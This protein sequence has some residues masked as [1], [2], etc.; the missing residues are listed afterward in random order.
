MKSFG[1]RK[2]LNFCLRLFKYAKVFTRN[3]SGTTTDHVKFFLNFSHLKS[4]HKNQVHGSHHAPLNRFF[5]KYHNFNL[6]YL[7]MESE[8]GLFFNNISNLANLNSQTKIFKT[9]YTSIIL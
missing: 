1:K 5:K 4:Y 7:H 3:I 8:S 2:L 6:S 9:N